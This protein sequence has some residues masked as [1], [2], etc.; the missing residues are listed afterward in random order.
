MTKIERAI[1][2]L[3]ENGYGVYR[4]PMAHLEHQA[5][6][7]VAHGYTIPEFCTQY[8][9]SKSMFYRLQRDGEGPELMKV[10]KRTIISHEAARAWAKAKEARDA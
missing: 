2:L 4:V 8:R 5:A 7:D 3:V 1:L 9:I 6:R 10:G